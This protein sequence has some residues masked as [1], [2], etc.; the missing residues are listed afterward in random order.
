MYDEKQIEANPLFAGFSDVKIN[1]INYVDSKTQRK[2]ETLFVT[3]L[4]LK[5]KFLKNIIGII[6]IIM[7]ILLVGIVVLV[8]L[9]KEELKVLEENNL[10]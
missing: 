5:E 2:K 6:I 3:F 8:I 9:V 7:R 1:E 4:N 10:N